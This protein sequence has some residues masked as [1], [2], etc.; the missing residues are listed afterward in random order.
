[1]SLIKHD[2]QKPSPLF[3]MNSDF[4]NLIQGFF[5]PIAN[6][7]Y[8]GN[9]VPEV[10]IDEKE[11]CYVVSAEMPGFDRED[12]EVKFQDGV[13]A[14]KAE[15]KEEI[16]KEEQGN[17]LNERHY[18]SFYRSLNFGNNVAESDVSAKYGKGILN[19]TI[20]KMQATP[21]KSILIDIK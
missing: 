12:I 3:S 18:E 19:L 2:P 14:I 10:N 4:N 16:K 17:V 6:T 11:D 21:T 8:S 20:P 9:R 7:E 1:M 5:H 13:L 15:H